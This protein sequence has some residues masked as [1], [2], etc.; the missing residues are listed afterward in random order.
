[1]RQRIH[2]SPA[3]RLVRSTPLTRFIGSFRRRLKRATIPRDIRSEGDLERRVLVPLATELAQKDARLRVFTHP[4]GRRRECVPDCERAYEEGQPTV[5]CWKCWRRTKRQWSV[6][7]YGT[8]HSFDLVATDGGERLALE[9][10]FLKVRGNRM[11]NGELQRFF[12]QCALAAAKNEYV[13]GICVFRG[14]TKA[15]YDYDRIA[16]KRWCAHGGI[17]LVMRS[18]GPPR[19]V[20]G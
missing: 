9:A 6:G 16:V 3:R 2:S 18:V 19:K 14:G 7:A 10:K 4:F 11:P 5:G 12:G 1:M 17:R 13:M 20:R 15:K 8:H